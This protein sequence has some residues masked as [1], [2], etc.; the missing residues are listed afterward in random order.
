MLKDKI[1]KWFEKKEER[2][3]NLSIFCIVIGTVLIS[4]G[5]GLTIISTQGLPA[6][7]A[8]VGSFLVFIFSIVFLIANLVKP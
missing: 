3:E 6:I 4:L 1:K 5:L 2:I 7:L 8:M